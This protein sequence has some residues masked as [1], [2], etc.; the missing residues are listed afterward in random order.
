M[1]K[2]IKV[3]NKNI[4]EGSLADPQGCAIA[5]S[6]KASIRN[7]DGVSVL[8]DQIKIFLKNGKSYSA[9]MPIEGT[10]FIKRFDRGQPVNPLK[11]KLE[12]V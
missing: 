4:Q 2:E 7:L 10:K 8:A 9:V 5:K 11:L 12:F 1:K 6:L 3:T